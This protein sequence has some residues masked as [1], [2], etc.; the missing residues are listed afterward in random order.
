L[1][2]VYG[3][4]KDRITFIPISLDWSQPAIEKYARDHKLSFN[5]YWKPEQVPLNI[6]YIPTVVLL[7]KSGAI[8]EQNVGAYP[9]ATF[10]RLLDSLSK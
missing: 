8:V 10:K 1:Q 4:Y 6:R 9:D 3:E 5:V 7:D 2:Q